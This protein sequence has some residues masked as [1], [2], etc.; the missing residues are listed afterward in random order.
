M[1]LPPIKYRVQANEL[2]KELRS[3]NDAL[4]HS[5]ASGRLECVARLGEFHAILFGSV[6]RHTVR[7]TEAAGQARYITVSVPDW[8]TLG[9]SADYFGSAF[10][11]QEF[12]L[13]SMIKDGLTSRRV[14]T[15]GST[16]KAAYNWHL[17]TTP[18]SLFRMDE[19]FGPGATVVAK[20]VVHCLGRIDQECWIEVLEIQKIVGLNMRVGEVHETERKNSAESRVSD[21]PGLFGRNRT[22]AVNPPTFA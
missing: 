3:S 7:S 10:R 19:E 8:S 22:S 13:R 17:P 6:L 11:N 1:L 2:L 14:T 5:G 9:W 16:K 12:I 18:P 21:L 20:V 15:V 4:L